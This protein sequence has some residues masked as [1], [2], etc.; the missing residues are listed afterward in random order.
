MTIYT[1]LAYGVL[2]LIFFVYPYSFQEVRG[3]SLET[4]SLP[5]LAVAAGVLFAGL[6]MAIF[7]KLWWL[8]RFLRNR[9]KVNPEDRIFP[10]IASSIILP[11]GL[12]W[13]AWT[14]NKNTTWVPQVLA[15]IFIG[16]GIMLPFLSGT[17]YLIDVYLL[18]AN[19]ALAANI[20]IRSMSAA[21]FPLFGKPMYERLGVAWATSLL[22]FFCV[23]LIP[24]PIVLWRY[25]EKI[26]GLSKY[27][28]EL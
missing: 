14:S 20:C 2:Y 21:V 4:A 12:F 26:R 9:M 1:S 16:A 19:S 17:A 3:W 24:F 10:L 7:N 23:A 5:F 6:A 8:P 15:G 22:A 28:F 27:S 18:N 13:F 25:G 11:T